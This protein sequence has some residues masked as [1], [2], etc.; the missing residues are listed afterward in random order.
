MLR[1]VLVLE[2][3]AVVAASIVACT[4]G[5]TSTPGPKGP[6][7]ID[8]AGPGI[9]EDSGSDALVAPDTAPADAGVDVSDAGADVATD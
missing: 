5:E 8:E 1:R 2:A 3:A 7:P 6:G 4:S 9:V